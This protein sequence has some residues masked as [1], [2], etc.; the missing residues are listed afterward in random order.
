MMLVLTGSG[1]ERTREEMGALGRRAGL[2]V[3]RVT[4]LATGFDVTELVPA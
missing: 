2:R 1:R 4:P 3:D